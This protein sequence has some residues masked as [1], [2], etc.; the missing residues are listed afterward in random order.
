MKTQRS[1]NIQFQI[2][3][4]KFSILRVATLLLVLALSTVYGAVRYVNLNSASPTAPFTSWSTAA[5]N[6]QDAVDIA[7][8]GD[9]IVVTN[10]LY[11]SG[12]R[13]GS[14]SITN[15]VAVDKAVSVRSLNGPQFT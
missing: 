6:I 2:S 10:G 11:G 4:R 13:R 12:G 15:R 14:G 5:T 3:N 9:E 1:D 8:A 7:T